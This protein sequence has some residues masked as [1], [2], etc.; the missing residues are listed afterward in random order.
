MRR[1]IVAA[2][3]VVALFAAGCQDNEA[4]NQNAK[5]QAELDAMKAKQSGGG[6]DALIALLANQNKGG[7]SSALERKLTSLA[8]DINAGQDK[9][10]KKLEDSDGANKKRMDDLED[11]LKQVNDLQSTITTLKTMIESLETKVKNVDPNEV[12]NAQK[13]LINKEA[14]LRME[15]QARAAAESQIEDLKK[16]LADAQAEIE[17]VKGEMVGLQGSDISKHPDYKALESENRKLKSD[18]KNAQT[19]YDN[20]KRQYDAMVEQLKKGSNP[21]P[22]EPGPAVDDYDFSGSVTEV[23]KGSRPDGPS[24]LLI[25]SLKGTVPAIGTEMVVLDAKQNPVCR[26]KIVRHY[27]FSDNEDLPVEEVG[28]QTIDEQVSRPVAKGDTVAYVKKKD[29]TG[30]DNSGKSDADANKGSAGG[31]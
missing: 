14:D 15:K 30:G 18:L 27:H 12:L 19:D 6:N 2:V 7:D 24:Y 29:E 9:I 13:E 23:S 1:M 22:E 25:A 11:K 10:E 3:A 4:R 26:V 16:Q 28:C 17:T 21:V 31:D 20:L 8:E 5:L